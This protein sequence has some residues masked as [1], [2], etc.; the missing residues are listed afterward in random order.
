MFGRVLY[1]VRH[2]RRRT[3]WRG[4]VVTDGHTDPFEDW[5]DG[6]SEESLTRMLD[7]FVE[8]ESEARL[9]ARLVRRVLDRRAGPGRSARSGA[10]PARENAPAR[11]GGG[12]G[13]YTGV[14]RATLVAT[15]RE[16]GRPVSPASLCEILVERGHTANHGSVRTALRRAAERG[17]L[18]RLDD[19]SYVAAGDRPGPAENEA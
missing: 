12:G 14:S 6:Q 2:V 17:E 11:G 16:V 13:R 7:T 10:A 3:D 5:L 4:R 9:K 15:V 8:Q 18:E 1:D 19:R